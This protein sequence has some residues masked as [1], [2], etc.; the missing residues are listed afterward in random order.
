MTTAAA[1]REKPIPFI[2]E[3]V[4]AILQG[5]KTQTR[6]V[7]KDWHVGPAVMG[8]DNDGMP[9]VAIGAGRWIRCPYGAPGDRLWVREAWAVGRGYDGLAPRDL[10][11]PTQ[12]RIK[13]WHLADGPKPEWAGKTRPPMFMP[14]WASRINLEITGVRVERLQEISEADANAEGFQRSQMGAGYPVFITESSEKFRNT[15]NTLNAA[16]GFAWDA[17][18]WVWVIEFKQVT[19]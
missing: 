19:Q 2:G 1:V 18:P 8:L 16:R 17:N 10:P 5:R 13:L 14:R 15:W 11:T 9:C 4:S 12:L 7:V 3:L 6:R